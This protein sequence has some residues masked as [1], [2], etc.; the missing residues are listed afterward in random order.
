MKI[1][2]I[3]TTFALIILATLIGTLMYINAGYV[4]IVFKN[5]T[6]ET[7]LWAFLLIILI[8][9]FALKIILSLANFV[10]DLPRIVKNWL[11]RVHITRA[12]RQTKL[13]LY[14]WT[15]GKWHQA[16]SMLING[17]KYSDTT[18]INYLLAASAAHEQNHYEQRDFYLQQAEKSEDEGIAVNLMRAKLYIDRSKLKE[19]ELILEKLHNI[20]PR[21]T[22]ILKLLTAT[23]KQ[24]NKWIFLKNLLPELEKYKVFTEAD[25]TQLELDTYLNILQKLINEQKSADAKLVADN[26]PKHLHNNLSLQLLYADILQS[27][28]QAHAA[29]HMLRKLLNKEWNDD[30]IKKYGEINS[31]KPQDQLAFAES[32]LAEYPHNTSLLLCLGKLCKKQKIWGK[33][34]SYLETSTNITPQKEAFL[35][36]ADLY[37]SLGK[38]NEALHA[39]KK[40]LAI[41]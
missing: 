1:K 8:I 28:N 6:I 12:R 17:A 27:N 41:L 36:L 20:A 7:T 26:I 18:T 5:W 19:A 39:Y 22:A 14:A 35:E 11:R 37:E 30:L 21:N 10:F 32:F 40:A 33:A 31:Y 23:Y 9:L 15:R 34:I 38:T 4:L 25:L 13:G 24:Q 29:E 3:I 16:E 2:K